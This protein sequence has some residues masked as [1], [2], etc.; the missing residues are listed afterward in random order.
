MK[1]IYEQ[2]QDIPVTEEAMRQAEQMVM[3]TE[4]EK[5]SVKAY[6]RSHSGQRMKQRRQRTAWAAAAVL[7]LSIG[8]VG[9]VGI[10]HPAYAAGLPIVGDIF[11]LLDNGRT[12]IYDLY[13]DNAATLE[14]SQTDQGI[15]INL[16]EAV[17][18][19]QSVYMTYEI[20]SEQELSDYPW[21]GS[22]GDFWIKGYRGGL[23]GGESV[24]KVDEGRYVGLAS[25]SMDKWQDNVNC[26]WHVGG[27]H[28]AGDDVVKGNWTF[29]FR[30]RAVEQERQLIGQS[31]S[32][33]E[34][35]LAVIVDSLERTAMSFSINYT[36]VM[37]EKY[38]GDAGEG[39]MADIAVRDDLGN[40]YAGEG[41]GGHGKADNSEVTFRK[42]FE[43]LDENASQLIITPYFEFHSVSGGG[44]VYEK[45]GTERMLDEW[46][47]ERE[48]RTVY[49]DEIVVDLH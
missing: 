48:E 3:V 6:V 26:H 1:N 40:V 42:T 30:L 45:D 15:T 10:N 23:A 32:E 31:V 41:Q 5:A 19:G 24:Q 29:D 33:D 37:P 39:I 14:L 28:L 18:D 16:R 36:Q 35:N 22:A 7:V 27:I 20:L 38:R 4:R 25:Y 9:Y 47:I 34:E 2:L 44:V 12:G 46:H 8:S 13:Q 11:R 21:I 49:L 43:K 17:F